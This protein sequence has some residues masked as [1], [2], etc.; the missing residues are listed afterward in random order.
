MKLLG[1]AGRQNRQASALKMIMSTATAIN[2]IITATFGRKIVRMQHQ[3]VNNHQNGRNATTNQKNKIN[4]LS[5]SSY[6]RA[7]VCVCAV[8]VCVCQCVCTCV[9]KQVCACD[10]LRVSCHV[11]PGMKH[12]RLSFTAWVSKSAHSKPRRD[13]ILLPLWFSRMSVYVLHDYNWAQWASIAQ[14][15]RGPEHPP[16]ACSKSEM[17]FSFSSIVHTQSSS[18][19]NC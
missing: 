13:P 15:V 1:A 8:C 14:S 10:S 12:E 19:C 5:A 4:R 7:R 16:A 11:C 9:W 18:L 3:Q 6:V 2:I 17:I